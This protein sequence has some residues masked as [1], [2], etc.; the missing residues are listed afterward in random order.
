[1]SPEQFL[2]LLRKGPAP[3]ACLLL[4]AEPYRREVCRKAL[5]RCALGEAEW[6][7]GLTRFDLQETNWR[8]IVDDACA[9]SL[10]APRRL[11]WVI[12][13]E[14]ALPKG[15]S[16]DAEAEIGEAPAATS[17]APLL[18]YL[19]RPAPGVTIALEA[20]RYEL[21]GEEKAKAERVRKLYGAVPV[22][23]EFPKLTAAE[24]RQIAQRLAQQAGLQFEPQALDAL[25]DTLGADGMRIANEIE[26]L[27]LHGG[28]QGPIT[29]SQLAALVPDS[30]VSTIFALVDALGRRDR[31]AALE[32]TDRL[33]RQGEYM[34]LALSFL[35]GLLRLA[36]AT[37]EL[38]LR[39]PQQVQ[40]A[41]SKPGRQLWPSRAQQIL[42]AARLFNERQLAETLIRIHETD[43]AFRETRPDD[44][45]IM[46]NFIFGMAPPAN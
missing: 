45:L 27:R 28:F 23:V 2:Q 12:N 19:K 17:V 44:R 37:R 16:G 6:E 3:P 13:V 43:R 14:A 1:L 39:T 15:R 41:F 29:V 22:Q 38:R 42:Q 33:L 5:L 25:V 36:L 40:Q 32:I 4:G 35:S 31:K 10:F 11:I 30:S 8:D 34:P 7:S 9:L 18:E 21:E 26:K 46:E 24:A 20:S